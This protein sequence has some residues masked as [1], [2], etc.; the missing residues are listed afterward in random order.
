SPA[1]S[2]GNAPYV[3]PRTKNFSSPWYRNLPRAVTG[4]IGNRDA[5]SQ[6]DVVAGFEG[7]RTPSVTSHSLDL[8]VVNESSMN[9][10]VTLLSFEVET[11]QV[12][13]RFRMAATSD[14]SW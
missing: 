9:G 2:G 11:P 1:A 4:V 6:A 13:V 3:V 7:S 12:V 10:S 14:P 5:R 8:C